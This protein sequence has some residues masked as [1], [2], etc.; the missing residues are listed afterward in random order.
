MFA[1]L[2]GYFENCHF[3]VESSVATFW[4]IF[5]QNWATFGQNWATIYFTSYLVRNFFRRE[6]DGLLRGHHGQEEGPIFA[7]KFW[8]GVRFV[9]EKF[10]KTL[11]AFRREPGHE[12]SDWNEKKRHPK[13]WCKTFFKN[14]PARASFSFIFVFSRCNSNYS[15]NF[16]NMNW[17]KRDGLFFIQTQDFNMVTSDKTTR[18]TWIVGKGRLWVT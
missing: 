12:R 9:A 1:N 17:I 5:R 15:C 6:R 18:Q 13:M 11:N 16:N 7:A 8:N 4:A 3:L 2:L 10:C 14:G